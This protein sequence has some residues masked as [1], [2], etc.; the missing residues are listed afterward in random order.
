MVEVRDL[1]KRYRKATANA[2]DGISFDVLP[3]QLFC[4]LGPNG[5]GK[6]TAISI[7]TTTLAP[8]SGT[9][10]IGG[11]DL[12]TQ[13]TL[14]R[15]Q[16][17]IV[18]QQPSL[19]M[20]LS[21]EENVRFHAVLYGLYPWRPVYRLMPAEYRLRVREL[22]E[23]LG[24]DGEMGKPV[25]TFSGGMR[26]KLEIVRTLLHRP[27][28]LFLDEPTTGLDP[29]SRRSLWSYLGEVRANAGTTIF[30]TTHYLDETEHADSICVLNHGRV[31]ATGSAAAVKARLVRPQLVIDA[32]PDDRPQLRR[33]LE[34]LGIEV[35]GRP[36]YR[37]KLERMRAQTVLRGLTVDLI[38]L[39]ITGGT[40][41]DAY[42]ALVGNAEGKV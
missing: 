42:L 40:M 38:E 36:P 39:Q 11:Y 20:N 21:A 22:A 35:S 12:A 16:V 1:V 32:A 23:L 26:R 8:T 29:E 2:V 7:L 25:R 30:L 6:T 27:Q 41:E 28:V 17:G 37:I 5:A 4:L 10:R 9:V 31:V 33:D 19:D 15:Q 24:L 3:G 18:F 14:V 13:A 34:K